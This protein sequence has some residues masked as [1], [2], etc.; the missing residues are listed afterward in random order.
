MALTQ[1]EDTAMSESKPQSHDLAT[2]SSVADV[3]AAQDPKSRSNSPQLTDALEAMLNGVTPTDTLSRED[4]KPSDADVVMPDNIDV[5][6]VQPELILVDP[7]PTILVANDAVVVDAQQAQSGAQEDSKTE[8]ALDVATK[9]ND[10]MESP[11]TESA[12]DGQARESETGLRNVSMED[13]ADETEVTTDPQNDVKMEGATESAPIFLPSGK[14]YIPNK[15]SENRVDDDFIIRPD[16]V[17]SDDEGDDHAEWEEDSSPYE[18]AP[19]LS[20]GELEDDDAHKD[21]PL[22]SPEEQ[23]RKLM[24]AIKDDESSSDTS[25]DSS[26]DDSSDDENDKLE[27]LSE[28][29]SR[30]AKGKVRT[31]NEQAEVVILQPTIDVVTPE[32]KIVALGK[33]EHIV[34]NTLIIPGYTSGQQRVLDQ[35]SALCLADRSVIGAVADVVGNVKTPVYFVMF[36]DLQAIADAKVEAGTE[37]FYVESHAT[38]AF[39]QNLY[40]KGTDASNIYDE[41]V[42]DNE[43][44]F[45]DDE[46]EMEHKRKLKYAKLEKYADS[47]VVSGSSSRG[48][49]GRGGMRGNQRGRANNRGERGGRQFQDR[50]PYTPPPQ[51]AATLNYDDDDDDGP[52]RPLSRPA[53]LAN[54]GA[55]IES[56]RERTGA[57]NGLY[58]VRGRGGHGERGRDNHRGDRNNGR[59]DRGR[60]RDGNSGR[61]RGGGYQNQSNG[62]HHQGHQTHHSRPSSSHSQHSSVSSFATSQSQLGHGQY[63][64][65]NNQNSS[66]PSSTRGF[67]P[68]PPHQQLPALPGQIP[69]WPQFPPPP[70]VPPNGAQ[71]QNFY[72]DP[73]VQQALHLLQSVQHQSPTNSGF[74]PP[75]PLPPAGFPGL[76]NYGQ[77]QFPQPQQHNWGYQNNQHNQYN[78]TNQNGQYG[79]HNHN[80]R[81]GY[82]GRGRGY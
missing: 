25:D 47:S 4:A 75:P 12:M 64:S 70:P 39:T 22:L 33:V 26:S 19:E 66:Q 42:D 69:T 36:K 80:Q 1:A 14:P 21:Y 13:A 18:S 52:Y 37:I 29:E 62:S 81:G 28:E 76:G 38:Y 48:Q 67:S 10:R 72:Q 82:N 5:T 17:G 46:K 50:V 23:A 15:V 7:V 40:T 35:G 44:E 49:R 68:P 24:D 43:L 57:N 34:D 16:P 73:R 60:G 3:P 58:A 53:S 45:S 9:Q 41:E 77:P 74:P 56:P 27:M 65:R 55:I 32:M 78:Q 63:Q 6:T 51:Y 59:N 11:A 30:A 54:P 2:I 61:G 8:V 71:I 31:K 79:G 20:D